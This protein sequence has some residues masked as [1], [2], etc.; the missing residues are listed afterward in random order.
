MYALRKVFVHSP[1][2]YLTAL[3]LSIAVMLFRRW[4]LPAEV[5]TAFAMYECF[6]VAGGVTFLV[7]A[8]LTVAYFGAFKLFGY[9]FS[10][11]RVGE[12]RKYKNYAHYCHVQ[13]EN[14]AR[15]DYYFV[16][17]YV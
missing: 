8:L 1:W 9:V 3:V 16:P 10:P 4:S 13:E 15:Q 12:H 11:G 14:R 5:G 7:G 2:H 17:Y 6:S